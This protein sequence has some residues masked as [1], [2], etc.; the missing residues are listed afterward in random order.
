M[1]RSTSQNFCWQCPCPHS[2][3]QPPPTS[4]GD[5]PTL[6]GMSGSVSCGVTAPSPFLMHTVLCVCPPRVKSL[7]PPVLSKSCNQITVTF[8]VWFSE[9]SPSCC[10]T[11]RLGSLTW[12][13]E[14]SL[15][16]VDFC[17]IIV[18]QFVSHPPSGH[19]IWFYCGCAPL[20]S[21]CGFFFVFGWGV[22]FFM[23]SS[24]FLLMI[25]QQLVVIP[26]LS[27][28]GVSA[29][30]STPLSLAYACNY[31]SCWLYYLFLSLIRFARWLY[32]FW[33]KNS[34]LHINFTAFYTFYV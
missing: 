5:P 13:S 12:A 4:A 24:V 11:P 31:I 33:W 34:H 25:V 23:S 14:T 2:E 15:Q 28:E 32:N 1:P 30:P 17:G 3:P 10:H 21:H 16:C 6:A 26:V 18:L 20:L 22:S 8:E 27:Q 19:G 9:N 29:R 7:F